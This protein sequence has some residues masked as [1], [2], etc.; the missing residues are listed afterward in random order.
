MYSYGPLHM[1]EQQGDQLDNTWTHI[2]VNFY[3]RWQYLNP[4]KGKYFVLDDKYLN[5]YNSKF[6]VLDSN[7]WTY[8]TVFFFN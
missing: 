6:F 7:S 3:I 2:T 5:Q 4:Y 8:M 1:A